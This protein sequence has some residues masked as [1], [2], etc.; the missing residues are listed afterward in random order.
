MVADSYKMDSVSHTSSPTSCNLTYTQQI[1]ESRQRQ[2]CPHD[3]VDEGLVACPCLKPGEATGTGSTS[4]S[5]QIS[6][7]L[8]LKNLDW[9]KRNRNFPQNP[10][11]FVERS[12]PGRGISEQKLPY[13]ERT[14]VLEGLPW[15]LP[16][17]GREENGP[18][19]PNL[20]IGTL[21]CRCFDSLSD[22]NDSQV[23]RGTAI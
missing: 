11:F 7:S 2:C 1:F 15:P 23:C 22:H 3:L 8:D 20:D 4:I 14:P 16:N 6:R 10:A 21:T 5:T 18:K 19:H 12:N 9:R 17:P 13:P